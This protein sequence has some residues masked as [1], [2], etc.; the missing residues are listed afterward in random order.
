M[1][2]IQNNSDALRKLWKGKEP[3]HVYIYKDKESVPVGGIA[4]WDSAGSN[5][6][7][8]IKQFRR[9][10]DLDGQSTWEWGAVFEP[11][12]LY[13]VPSIA[14]NANA[15]VLLVEGEKTAEAA[16]NL[17]PE[18]VITTTIGGAKASQ[19]TDFTPLRGRHIILAQ[20]NDSAGEAYIAKVIALCCQVGTASLRVMPLQ[21]FV[22]WQ[23]R[24]GVLTERKEGLPV[25][26]DLADAVTEGWTRELM[27]RA[28]SLVGGLYREVIAPVNQDA[29][30]HLRIASEGIQTVENIDPLPAG[31]TLTEQGLYF[32]D[33]RLC[34]YIRVLACTRD[35]ESQSWGRQIELIDLD[36]KTH[37]LTISMAELGGASG[38]FFGHLLSAGVTMDS[39]LSARSKIIYF[40]QNTRTNRRIKCVPTIGWHGD[41]Y[42]LPNQV[43]PATYGLVLQSDIGD[44][45][46]HSALGSLQEWQEKIAMLCR[47]NSRLVLALSSAFAAPLL[48]LLQHEN[49][50]FHFKGAS[51]IGKT[52]ALQVSTSVWGSP[53]L[54]ASWKATSNALEAVAVSHNDALLSLDELGQADGKCVGEVIYMLANGVGKSRMKA[55]GGLR[56]TLTWRT[57]ILSTGEISIDDKLR[58]YNCK[59]QAGMEARLIEVPADTESG[60]RL[61]DTLHEFKNGSELANHL[62]EHTQ[63]YYGSAIRSFLPG[64]IAR[65]EQLPTLLD[66]MFE[67]FLEQMDTSQWSGQVRRVAKHFA[68]VALGGEL[69]IEMGVLPFEQ[70][71]VFHGIVKCFRAWLEG[72]GDSVDRELVAGI[73]Q[74]RQ[75]FAE[76]Q[77]SRFA[78]DESNNVEN[79]TILKLAGYKKYVKSGNETIGVEFFVFS[80]TFRTE[81]SKGFDSK[82]IL[83]EL[84]RRG[85]LKRGSEKQYVKDKRLPTGGKKKMYHIVHSIMTDES[86]M[87]EEVEAS[88]IQ[89]EQVSSNIGGTWETGET[90]GGRNELESKNKGYRSF[91]TMNDARVLRR[92]MGDKHEQACHSGKGMSPASPPLYQQRIDTEE[93]V[94]EPKSIET[95]VFGSVSPVSPVSRADCS[96]KLEQTDPEELSDERYI[97]EERLAIESDDF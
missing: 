28:G 27:E 26:Y 50:G 12:P 39:T 52:T 41:Y 51:S 3:D 21:L 64:V 29:H 80:E 22:D 42:V 15:T 78:W 61:F 90:K 34:S 47:G 43:V 33:Q 77:N 88:N 6:K 69:A 79:K 95:A 96:E 56:K 67:R 36:G 75:F 38:E 66:T 40:L 62:K 31:Y 57:I 46:G 55:A 87:D 85:M 83:K 45:K 63:S 72:R 53:K 20:D 84:H 93:T 82:A 8:T 54:Q 16:K 25:G 71:E 68:L 81:I 14:E 74:V 19:K 9:V 49:F 48:S 37:I 17:F 2:N 94:S 70:N 59:S 18:Y 89:T 97:V 23:I 10:N 65:K 58:E 5:E 91:N 92:D 35:E 13:Q 30:L 60:Y 76:Y 11:R 7:K 4:R 44:I 86:E 32:N 1:N 24:E 73:A